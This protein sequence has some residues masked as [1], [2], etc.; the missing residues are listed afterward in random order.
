M[1]RPELSELGTRMSP[2][3]AGWRICLASSMRGRPERDVYV[4]SAWHRHAR[5][6]KSHVPEIAPVKRPEG[7]APTQIVVGALPGICPKRGTLES[8]RRTPI[9]G[10][11]AFRGRPS[12]SFPGCCGCPVRFG[13]LAHAMQNNLVQSN[14]KGLCKRNVGQEALFK[15]NPPHP[16]PLPSDG[17][18]NSQTPLS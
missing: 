17:R 3:P 6:L 1:A 16:D 9:P 7:R 18:G 12:L 5:L 11:S 14:F 10:L 4:A 13:A 2:E 15:Q 8:H